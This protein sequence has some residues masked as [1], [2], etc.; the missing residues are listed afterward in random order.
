MIESA[1]NIFWLLI[2]IGIDYPLEKET[3]GSK[4]NNNSTI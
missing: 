1:R 4:L 3:I 2:E